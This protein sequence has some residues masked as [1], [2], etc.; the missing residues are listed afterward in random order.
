MSSYFLY[1]SIDLIIEQNKGFVLLCVL[2][3]LAY[4]Y[5]MYVR[6]NGFGDRSDRIKG[7]LFAFRVLTVFIIAFLL[8]TPFLRSLKTEKEKPTI[9]VAQDASRSVLKEMSVSSQQKYKQDLYKLIEDLSIDYLVDTYSFGQNVRNELALDFPDPSSNLAAFFQEMYDLYSNQNLGAI[10]WASDGI[11]NQGSDPLYMNDRI[12]VPVMS[13]A[14]G[15]TSIKKDL[16]LKK[17][18]NNQIAYLGDKFTVQVDVSSKNCTGAQTKMSVFSGKK[19]VYDKI[20]E[21]KGEDYFETHEI[22]LDADITG[23]QKFTIILSEIDGELTAENNQKAFYIDVLDSRQKVL[24]LANAPHPDLGTLKRAILTNKNFEVEIKYPEKDNIDLS[25]TDLLIFHQ[26]PSTRL[27]CKAIFDEA[28]QK[29]I[30]QML[31]MG[32]Q[33]NIPNFSIVQQVLEVIKRG[34]QSNESQAELSPEFNFFTL[35]DPIRSLVPL[36]PPVYTNFADYKVK[37]DAQILMKQKISGVK[38]NFPLFVFGTDQGIKKAIISGEGIWKWR[39]VDFVQNNSFDNFDELISKSVQYLSNKEDKRRFKTF[40]SN[41]VFD[42]SE[43]IIIDAELYNSNYERINEPEVTLRLTN[44]NKEEFQYTFSKTKN[45]YQLK[46]GSLAEGKYKYQAQTMFN[47]ESFDSEGSFV[48]KTIELEAFDLQANHTLL[49]QISSRTGGQVFSPEQINQV[50]DSIV[51][52]NLVKP[53]LYESVRT[54]ALIHEKWIF[55]LL[56]FLLSSEWFFRRFFG[57]Y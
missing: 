32:T 11:Y 16:V 1:L 9:I 55:V 6:E 31:I 3:A 46:I 12:S 5:L 10:I 33:T 38:T 25:E 30:A 23:T 34:N 40:T 44:D 53:V 22:V 8:L 24:I 7:L 43:S 4:A 27:N 28:Q 19:K 54:R 56:L 29:K 13:I 18:F 21:I 49:H 14:L 39:M 45:A 42:E 41:S 51:A 37:K 26:L 2:L 48:V 50:K 52:S 47:N 57:A 35:S 36:L 17:I 20:I 15:D